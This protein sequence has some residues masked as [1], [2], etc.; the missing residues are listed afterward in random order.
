ML[1]LL[2]ILSLMLIFLGTL[3]LMI[4]L[5]TMLLVV[6]PVLQ[7]SLYASYQAI[8]AVWEDDAETNHI[9]DRLA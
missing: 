9:V 2:L 4:V 3:G 7:G 5:P 8:F 1:G 6:P